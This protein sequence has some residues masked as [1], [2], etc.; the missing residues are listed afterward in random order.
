M[1]FLKLTSSWSH[2]SPKSDPGSF[3]TIV[4]DAV[5]WPF[6]YTL[7]AGVQLITLGL[8]GE[9]LAR[10]YHESQ[11][12]PIYVVAED[13]PSRRAAPRVRKVAAAE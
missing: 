8:L 5:R 12:K 2:R 9:M 13:L 10:T 6:G 7:A 11:G 4:C 1:F 3:N